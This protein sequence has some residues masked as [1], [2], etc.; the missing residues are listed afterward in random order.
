MHRYHVQIF[1][2]VCW[3][4]IVRNFKI[5]TQEQWQNTQ[6]QNLMNLQRLKFNFGVISDDSVITS[7]GRWSPRHYIA[8]RG[9]DADENS[10]QGRIQPGFCANRCECQ[11]D[12][13]VVRT[14]IL[15]HRERHRP[16]A[17][18]YFPY[19][20][21]IRGHCGKVANKAPPGREIGA[22]AQA[23]ILSQ[24]R[25]VPARA[26]HLRHRA[27]LTKTVHSQYQAAPCSLP[28]F[29]GL[30]LQTTARACGDGQWPLYCCAHTQSIAGMSCLLQR[31][32]NHTQRRPYGHVGLRGIFF[33]R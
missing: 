3:C 27:V 7:A 2:P 30:C 15:Q 28:F 12:Y 29:A 11:A 16:I 14:E 20:G 10:H 22:S 24:P 32:C 18:L 13:G 21:F 9:S 31:R 17:C 33:N 4:Q 23:A 25:A 8:Q 19:T 26:V 6:E 1:D 5:C